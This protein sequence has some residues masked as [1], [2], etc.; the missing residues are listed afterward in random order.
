MNALLWSAAKPIT[1]TASLAALALI[2]THP[3]AR[4]AL[5]S[6]RVALARNTPAW[7]GTSDDVFTPAGWDVEPGADDRTASSEVEAAAQEL[8]AVASALRE[9]GDEVRG[10]CDCEDCVYI[11]DV[12]LA[13]YGRVNDT[14]RD[15]LA[16][17]GIAWDEGVA[18]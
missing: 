12:L 2:V 1:F 10:G 6:L 16:G 3:R 8:E 5:W 17:Y 4:R 18:S 13:L 9:C 7:N 14:D 15:L 11:R